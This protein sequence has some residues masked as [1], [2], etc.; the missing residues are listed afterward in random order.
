VSIGSITVLDLAN[1]RVVLELDGRHARKIII[2]GTAARENSALSRVNGWKQLLLSLNTSNGRPPL[3]IISTGLDPQL[4][5]PRLPNDIG[6][7]LEVS[8]QMKFI[9]SEFLEL[10]N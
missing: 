10:L 9:P 6:F 5:L 7:P 1:D 2:S 8:V 3:R 4:I